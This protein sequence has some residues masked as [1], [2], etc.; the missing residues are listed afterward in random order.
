MDLET[1]LEEKGIW[2]RFVNKPETIHTA[3]ASEKT[4]ID[5]KKI[6]KSLIL[7]DQDKNPIMAI[8]PG[9]CKLSFKKLKNSIEAKKV[10]LVP[11]EDAK[12]Y[13]GYLPGATPMIH[14]KV[15]MKVIIDKRLSKYDTIFGGGGVRTKLLELKTDDVI[16]LNKALVEDIVE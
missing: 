10:R 15:E 4:G 3:D 11:F 9:N 12:N 2:H 16:R 7:L 8:I 6:T 5:L 1:Y 13:S 14:H